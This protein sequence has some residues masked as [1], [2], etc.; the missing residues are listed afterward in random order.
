[1]LISNVTNK[2]MP[3]IKEWQSCPLG[4]ADVVAFLGVIYYN[5]SWTHRFDK[6][7]KLN[8]GY[9]KYNKINDTSNISGTTDRNRFYATATVNF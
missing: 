2:L 7:T 4:K 6:N 9:Y 8:L 5:V 3:L 1:M